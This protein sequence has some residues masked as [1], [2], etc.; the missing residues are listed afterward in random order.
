M[1]SSYVGNPE[2][3]VRI[4]L[5][6]DEIMSWNELVVPSP[7]NVASGVPTDDTV[8]TADFELTEVM[9]ALWVVNE[10]VKKASLLIPH[11]EDLPED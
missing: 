3:D 10:W 7:S 2:S 1:Y 4:E 9:T 6:I 11:N 8:W 5:F